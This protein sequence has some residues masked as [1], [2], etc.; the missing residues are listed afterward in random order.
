[1]R[2]IR[3]VLFSVVPIR[4]LTVG[5]NF[6]SNILINRSLG[7]ALKGQYTVIVNYASFVQLFFNLGICYAYPLL[8]NR[9]GMKAA[10][11]IILSLI[12][13]QTILYA[14]SSIFFILINPTK[15]IIF[16]VLLSAILICNSQMVFVALIDD[17]K[18]RNIILLSSTVLFIIC[19]AIC[20]VLA[21]GNVDIIVILLI[22]KYVYEIGVIVVCNK[23]FIFSTTMINRENIVAVLKIG[24]P[25]ACLAVLI[26]CNYNIDIL[27]LNWM[28]SGDVQVGMYG[29]A[30]SLTNIL[31]VIPD[32]F[33]ELIYNKTTSDGQYKYVVKCIIINMTICVF[34]TLGF[35]L[36]GK[37]FLGLVYG[38]EYMVA[39]K[40]TLTLFC[41]VIPMVAFKLIHPIYVNRG[42]SGVVVFLL[43]VAVTANIIT[44]YILIPQFG[45]LGAAIASVVS[46]SIC[47]F[48]FWVKYKKDNS[49]MAI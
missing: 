30:Y 11:E 48:L 4:V 25:T 27:M 26:I 7:L 46:Y 20:I 29:V 15:R 16:I 22:A 47:G 44:S 33:K 3:R 6:I 39:Y 37:S 17:I 10:K 5:L 41:G 21:P 24:I 43:C 34:I 1:M 18:R 42:K 9:E 19:N 45:A 28:N 2:I 40:V 35:M 31:W 13:L 23:Y 32:A 12:W 36:L 14:V 38:K 8:R 49:L